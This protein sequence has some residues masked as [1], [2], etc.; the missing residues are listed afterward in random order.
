MSNTETLATQ[1]INLIVP[2][3][4]YAVFQEEDRA[5]VGPEIDFES[6]PFYDAKREQDVNPDGPYLAESVIPRP[7]EDANF[8]LK[9]GGHLNWDFSPFLKRT[10]FR[11]SAPTEFSA[12]PT[13]RL[14]RRYAKSG[15]EPVRLWVLESDALL[16]GDGN[17]VAG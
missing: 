1:K 7:C 8:I 11:A 5:V 17:E 3:R 13:H 14:I 9:A 4:V 10:K 2:I 16:C 12:V 15:H 6:L